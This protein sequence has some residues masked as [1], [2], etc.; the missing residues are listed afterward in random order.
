MNFK[1]V[2]HFISYL[3]YP[4][5]LI[6]IYFGV[7]PY[8]SGLEMLVDNPDMFFNNLNSALIF[9]GLGTSF[10]SL[11]D[12]SKIQNNFSKNIWENPRKGKVTILL[13]CLAIILLLLMGLIGYFLTNDGVLKNLSVGIMV[14]SLGMFGFLKV[15]TEMF[16]NHKK[17]T[18]TE[19]HS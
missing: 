14:L 18:D 3:Q 12:T 16:E 6:G 7:I 10:A 8:L 5:M 4:L 19:F 11:Q 17:V 13:M 15:A 9:I 2:F 1:R